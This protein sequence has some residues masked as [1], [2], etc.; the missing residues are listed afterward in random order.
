MGNFLKRLISALVLLPPVILLVYKGSIY[1]QILV[2]LVVLLC[3]IEYYK[4]LGFRSY[5]FVFAII[6]TL[7]I[8]IGVF[9]LSENVIYW[10]TLLLIIAGLYI[11]FSLKE[12]KDASAR[13]GYLFTGMIYIGLFP[14]F[15]PLIREYDKENGFYYLFTFLSVIWLSDT[16]AYFAG[17]TFGRHKLY[18]MISPKK[19]IEGSVG[20]VI[21]GILG[22]YIISLFFQKSPSINFVL[23]VGV[24]VNLIGQ[25]GDLFESMF[26]RD[27]G[28]KDSGDL[29]PGHGGMLDR[30]DAIIFSAPIMYLILRF[31]L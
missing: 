23:L 16:F 24:L 30:V 14:S 19:T 31:V 2:G 22:V 10:I 7:L 3:S 27:K 4:M 15:I 9:S 29:I 20:G 5:D 26:K 28:I 12:V 8:Y 1:L 6:F 13:L 11:L 21:G 18:E 25:A 17:K